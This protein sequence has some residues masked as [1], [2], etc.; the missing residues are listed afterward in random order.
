MNPEEANEKI[1][2]LERENQ[3]LRE[4]IAELERRLALNSSNSSKPPAS[5]GFGKQT[6]RTQSLRK[7]SKRKS[8]GQPGHRGETLQAVATPDEVVTY[9]APGQCSGCGCDLWET[10]VSSL[11]RRQVFDVPKL[12]LAVTEHQVRVKHCPQCHQSVHHDFPEG[13]NAPVQ[14]G[15]RI[16]AIAL[17]LHHQHF[18]PEERLMELLSDVFSCSMV[19]GTLS[20]LTNTVSEAIEPVVERIRDNLKASPVKHLDET[21][22]RISAKT[23]WLHVVSSA[24]ETWYRIAS[25]RK[26][27]EPLDGMKG[28]V[29]HDHWKSYFQLAGVT[30][31][32]C[33]AHHLRE[34]KA[35]QDIEHESWATRMSKLLTL[36]CRYKNRHPKDI[37][38]TLQRR[39][40]TLYQKIVSRG[41]TFHES[42]PP[43]PRPSNRGRPKRRVG[44]NLLLR[45]KDYAEDVLRFLRQPEVPLTNN[46]AERDLR[47]MKL[48]QKISGGFR[49]SDKADAFARIRSVLSSAR[50]QGISLLDVLSLAV[51]GKTPSLNSNT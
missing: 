27:L 11:M 5:D 35:L 26:D 9:P 42:L 38:Q 7:K 33:N 8:G 25:K 13:V 36:A 14:Y 32:L 51:Q 21:G 24:T 37:P 2:Y 49:S 15:P 10:P 28:V 30:H 1:A 17:Y 31:G 4:R 44:H 43:L 16:R 23:Q 39:I 40:S 45:L 47:M 12:N 19:S 3:E 20:T 46:Q 34:L 29:V 22:L 41:L 50:K 6:R 18:V 48:K